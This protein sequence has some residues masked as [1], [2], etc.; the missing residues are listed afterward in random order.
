MK[1][2]AFSLVLLV[3]LGAGCLT[4]RS[5]APEV[6]LNNYDNAEFRFHFS[7]PPGLEIR[8]RETKVRPTEYLG[9]PADLFLSVRDPNR[10][11]Q[12]VTLAFFYA[13]PGL[14]IDD[15]RAH[16]TSD[17]TGGPVKSEETLSI[18]Q[19]S[20]EKIVNETPVGIDRVHYLLVGTDP[21]IVI[22]VFLGEEENFAP[23]LES[24]RW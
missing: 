17:P 8:E 19:Q 20:V 9:G 18:N 2:I 1:K 4:N 16:L 23:L 7:Y 3:L 6:E 13:I 5:A 24:L 14:S 10:E 15:F 21:L 11:E 22:S 12:P